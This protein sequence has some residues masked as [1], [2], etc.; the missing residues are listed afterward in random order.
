M[1]V[2]V[3]AAAYLSPTAFS[4]IHLLQPAH[5]RSRVAKLLAA[6]LVPANVHPTYR[7]SQNGQPACSS[8]RSG[9]FFNQLIVG[10]VWPASQQQLSLGKHFNQPIVGVV[11]PA[12]LQQLSFEN[13]YNQ[14]ITGVVY[15][16]ALYTTTE[17]IVEVAVW[18]DSV[19][20][21]S[22]KECVSISPSLEWCGQVLSSNYRAGGG[23]D[24]AN[25][26]LEF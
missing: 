17:P 26:S 5:H 12:S 8:C 15:S 1:V 23:V 16:Q 4:I 13:S 18:L 22:F 19:Q 10:A 14:P 25:P 3:R 24:S 6:P 21:L 11:W 20:Q 2:A 9:K 7:R